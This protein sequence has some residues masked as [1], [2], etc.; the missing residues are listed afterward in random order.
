MITQFSSSPLKD[1][2]LHLVHKMR[3]REVKHVA[4]VYTAREQLNQVLNTFSLEY[5]RFFHPTL[6][7]IRKHTVLIAQTSVR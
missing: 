6:L 5:M 1:T 4:C 7:H 3:I 2:K